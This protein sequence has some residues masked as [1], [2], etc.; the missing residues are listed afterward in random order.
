MITII[1]IHNDVIVFI[2]IIIV[3]LLWKMAQ[4]R[5]MQGRGFELHAS[6]SQIVLEKPILPEA[7]FTYTFSTF[8]AFIQG[9][10]Q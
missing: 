4:R 3:V 9:D 10:L 6:P 7:P 2:I 5:T 8:D 1:V